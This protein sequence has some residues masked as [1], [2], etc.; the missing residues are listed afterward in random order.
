MLIFARRVV[1][2]DRGRAA[3]EKEAPQPVAVIGSVAGQGTTRRDGADQDG[4]NAN[5]AAL[6]RRHFECDGSAAGIDDGVD[7]RRAPAARAANRLRV[8]PPFPPA[9]ERCALAVVLSMA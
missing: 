3:L 8:G 7:F 5:I 1:G 2:D 9:A 4:R 6:A